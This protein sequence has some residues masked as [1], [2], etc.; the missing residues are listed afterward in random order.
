MV[1][2]SWKKIF[3]IFLVAFAIQVLSG[4]KVFAQEEKF[5][6]VIGEI[7]YGEECLESWQIE[8]ASAVAD[9]LLVTAPE[10]PYVRFFAGEVRFYE[11][12]YTESL[13]LLKEALQDPELAQ[14]G[15]LFYDFVEKILSNDGHVQGG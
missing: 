11:G 1:S 13:S 10:N 9:K 14:K 15:K 7:T 2:S 4:F 6:D 8:E 3:N 12:N 5:F